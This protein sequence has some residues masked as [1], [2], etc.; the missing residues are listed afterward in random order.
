MDQTNLAFIISQPRAGSTLLQKI[1][2]SHS[3]V[4][5]PPEPWLMLPMSIVRKHD[6]KVNF[7]A[8][9]S[10]TAIN[11][12]LRRIPNGDKVYRQATRDFVFRIY[13][14]FLEQNKAQVFI[15]KTPRYYYILDYLNNMFPHAKFIVL[16]RHP[17]DVFVSLRDTFCGRNDRAAINRSG[18]S[19]MGAKKIAA[20]I[21][22]PV[23]NRKIIRYE[24]VVRTPGKTISEVCSFLGLDYEPAM[25]NYGN[26][27][28]G[29]GFGDPKINK[30]KAPHKKSLGQW[31]TKLDKKVAK[32][33]IQKIGPGVIKKLGYNI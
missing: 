21:D 16:L 31:R 15:D 7:A 30:S 25:L 28:H 10:G 17:L 9:H 2:N 8:D 13:G 18:D 14:E 29:N 23:K 27:N 11:Q 20:F 12:F 3:K 6:Y 26:F 5:S 4:C 1:L 19:I 33:V 32:E 24:D 22:K